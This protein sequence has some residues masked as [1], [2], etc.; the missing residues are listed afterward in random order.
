MIYHVKALIFVDFAPFFQFFPQFCPYFSHVFH[1]TI[2]KYVFPFADTFLGYLP[3]SVFSHVTFKQPFSWGFQGRRCICVSR[4]VQYLII[5]SRSYPA[6]LYCPFQTKK[7][8]KNSG[9]P[10]VP[11]KKSKIFLKFFFNKLFYLRRRSWPELI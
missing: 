3:F 1:V 4:K 8:Q 7:L 10:K 5:S 6:R 2:C 11:E 9:I